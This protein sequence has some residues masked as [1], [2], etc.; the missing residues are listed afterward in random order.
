MNLIFKN[1]NNHNK[2]S[3]QV[4]VIFINIKINE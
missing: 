3:R 4:F 2:K 1:Q